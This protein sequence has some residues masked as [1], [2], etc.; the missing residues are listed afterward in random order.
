MILSSMTNFLLI[1]DNFFPI[2]PIKYPVKNNYLIKIIL[3]YLI[4]FYMY[5]KIEKKTKKENIINV[6]KFYPL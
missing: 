4:F 2:E 3:K 1:F 6:L 5:I